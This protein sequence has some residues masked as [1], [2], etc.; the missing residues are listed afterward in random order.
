MRLNENTDD[1][2]NVRQN[3]APLVS[4]KKKKKKKYGKMKI[5]E[6]EKNDLDHRPNGGCYKQRMFIST[7]T[8]WAV[9]DIKCNEKYD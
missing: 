3:F 5:K 2:Y 6:K 7:C 8:V 1:Y 4:R 9:I